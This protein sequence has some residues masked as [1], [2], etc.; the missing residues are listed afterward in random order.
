M[1]KQYECLK[2]IFKRLWK[3][4]ENAVSSEP[5]ISNSQRITTIHVLLAIYSVFGK[6]LYT[7]KKVLEVISTGQ[8]CAV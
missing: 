3:M 4:G 5:E 6:S 2:L 8:Q 7:Y 1:I